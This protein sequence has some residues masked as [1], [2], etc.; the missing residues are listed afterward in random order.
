MDDNPSNGPFKAEVSRIESPSK[1][2]GA[3]FL[4]LSLFFWSG[5]NVYLF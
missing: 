4:P 3:V 2:I 5:E 1:V